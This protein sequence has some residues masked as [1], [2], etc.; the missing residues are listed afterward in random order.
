MEPVVPA[1]SERWT[2]DPQG[3]PH[4]K[5]LASGIARKIVSKVH[6]NQKMDF[7]PNRVRCINIS[8]VAFFSIPEHSVS[9][10]LNQEA[11][12]LAV[13]SKEI[14]YLPGVIIANQIRPSD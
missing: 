6:S 4:G 1:R 2:K 13:V 8:T 11:E 12:V 14:G 3:L 9:R 7:L 10:E 5:M